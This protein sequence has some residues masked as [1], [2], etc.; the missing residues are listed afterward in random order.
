MAEHI[1]L[2]HPR[3]LQRQFEIE[4]DS[5]DDQHKNRLKVLKDI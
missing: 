3:Q 1:I 4:S 2:P 5:E